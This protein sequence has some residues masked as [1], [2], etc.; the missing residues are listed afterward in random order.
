MKSATGEMFRFW[1]NFWW[2]VARHKPW[3]FT[4]KLNVGAHQWVSQG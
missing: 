2:M 4:R 1:P 3:S